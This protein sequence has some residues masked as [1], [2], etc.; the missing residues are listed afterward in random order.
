[1]TLQDIA[2]GLVETLIAAG[3]AGGRVV[4]SRLGSWPAPSADDV[5][6]QIAVYTL[7]R[8]E[9]AGPDDSL[10]EATDSVSIE[11]HA[12][13]AASDAELVA[14][15]RA[16]TRDVRLALWSHDTWSACF[17]TVRMR[18]RIH[19]HDPKETSHRRGF[20][21]VELTLT[22]YVTYPPAY[23]DGQPIEGAFFNFHLPPGDPEDTPDVV[24]TTEL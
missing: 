19:L 20:A 14:A 8:D 17:E 24:A 12:A 22:H 4:D 3:L 21:V 15:L 18:T 6:P 2:D 13:G 23:A 5:Y 7:D 9:G 10:V 1:M 11:V 16:T